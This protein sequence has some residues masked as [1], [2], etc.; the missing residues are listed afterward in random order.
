MKTRRIAAP[1]VVLALAIVLGPA[2]SAVADP[3]SAPVAASA[4]GDAGNLYQL[5]AGTLD[6]LFPEDQALAGDSPALALDVILPDGSMERTLVPGSEGPEVEGAPSVV[7]EDASQR[8]Y[9]VW[10][11]KRTPTVSRLLLAD[12]GANG[13]SDPIEIS[14]DIA[15][16][17]D[18]PRVLMARDR[19]TLCD[20]T[21]SESCTRSRTV[22][23]VV[24]REEGPEGAGFYYTPVI[25]ERGRYLGWNPVVALA[26]LDPNPTESTPAGA[27][28]LLRT[29]ELRNG[30]DVHSAI[31]G[32]L[33]P[34]SERLITVEFRLL[35]GEIGFLADDFRGQIIDIGARSRDDIEILADRFRGQIIDIGNRL[36]GGVVRALANRAHSSLLAL[37]D[38]DPGRPPTALAD[39]FRG[40]IIDIGAELLG[41][42]GGVA[43]AAELLQI[44]APENGDSAESSLPR[45]SHLLSVQVVSDLPTPPLHD[46]PARL[47]VSEDGEELVVGWTTNGKVFYT[48]SRQSPSGPESGPWTAVQHMTLTE[49][50]GIPEAAAILEARVKLQR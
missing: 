11:S 33:S 46:V 14:G 31:L 3:P 21:G 6:E 23:H 42:P 47:F 27:S 17:R 18:A 19:F 22:L 25:L 7:F 39:A 9:A 20:T 24:W 10:E 12:F 5:V 29:P 45:V 44:R 13:W 40:Q 15:P 38:A 34:S 35:P 32:Y 16:L 8:L 28:N 49:R 41:G 30:Q 26:D 50:L 4:L 1:S 37:H 43:R 48:E 2:L 36:N